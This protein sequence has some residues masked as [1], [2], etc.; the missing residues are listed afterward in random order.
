MPVLACTQALDDGQHAD[1][2]LLA[3]VRRL[4]PAARSEAERQHD[5]GTANDRKF[6]RRLT[7][8]AGTS[9]ARRLCVMAITM[10]I[11]GSFADRIW[12]D[13]VNDM[14]RASQTETGGRGPKR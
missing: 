11:R 8:V 6:T 2:T 10:T 14:I 5:D 13:L 4:V 12:P 3:S 1:E 9:P 7:T